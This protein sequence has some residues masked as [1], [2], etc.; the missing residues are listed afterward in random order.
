MYESSTA[1]LRALLAHP[2]LQRD[3]VERTFDA[4]A[5]ANADAQELDEA[6]RSGMDAAV[7][8]VGS[9]DDED[10]IKAE[11]AALEAEAIADAR[12]GEKAP[13]SLVASSATHHDDVS[14][15]AHQDRER[16]STR[17]ANAL[18]RKPE[19]VFAG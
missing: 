8:V 9:L 12:A 2:S 10:D 7:G 4:L 3:A 11:L 18:E 16:A 6:V 5:D 15:V 13:Q 14:E 1:T 19:Q 17:D